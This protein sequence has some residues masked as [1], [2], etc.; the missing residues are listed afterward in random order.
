MLNHAYCFQK[1]VGKLFHRNLSE[2]SFIK[3]CWKT[4]YRSLLENFLTKAYFKFRYRSV[5]KGFFIENFPCRRLLETFFQNLLV[6]F[7]PLW[8]SFLHMLVGMYLHRL[9]KIFFNS[10]KSLLL[11]ALKTSITIKKKLQ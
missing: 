11:D 6:S 7:L 2:S 4:S 3:A 10:I 8:K 1:L 5:L 9:V